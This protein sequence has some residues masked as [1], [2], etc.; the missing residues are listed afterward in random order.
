MTNPKTSDESDEW[1][2][3]DGYIDLTKVIERLD[4]T[5]QASEQ[6]PTED[7]HES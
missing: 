7:D 3:D 4:L 6:P 1:G 2:D 5:S